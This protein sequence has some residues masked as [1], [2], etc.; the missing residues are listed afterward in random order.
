M[1]LWDVEGLDWGSVLG[2]ALKGTQSLFCPLRPR[3]TGSPAGVACPLAEHQD[4][5]KIVGISSVKQAGKIVLFHWG[6]LRMYNSPY[7][8]SVL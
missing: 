6:Q 1:C 4:F 2:L 3:W 8:P 7:A 5:D